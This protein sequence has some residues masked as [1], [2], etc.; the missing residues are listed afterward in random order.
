MHRCFIS[1]DHAGCRYFEKVEPAD[2]AAIV[3][4]HG[5]MTG[6]DLDHLARI[7]EGWDDDEPA[8]AR[9]GR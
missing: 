7:A 2:I 1:Y 5:S 8:E 6:L 9:D 3:N 4:H